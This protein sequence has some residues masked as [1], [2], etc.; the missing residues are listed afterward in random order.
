MFHVYKLVNGEFE[1][2]WEYKTP[3]SMEIADCF[4]QKMPGGKEKWVQKM[5]HK[6]I[7]GSPVI[8]CVPLTEVQ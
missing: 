1:A 6:I 4:I 7:N 8:T 3:L 2:T 5:E